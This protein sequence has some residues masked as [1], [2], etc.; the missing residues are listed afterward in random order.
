MI[1]RTDLPAA[2]QNKIATAGDCWE[3]TGALNNRGYGAV[4]D[5]KG[6]SMLAH[7]K[8]YQLTIGA[9]PEGFEI[10][11]LCRM[12]ACINP[13]HLEAVTPDENKRR[14]NVTV[15]ACRS[16]HPLS[17]ANLRIRIR[18][19]KQQRQCITCAREQTRAAYARKQGRSIRSKARPAHDAL[20]ATF[21][22]AA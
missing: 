22:V 4:T 3:W 7:R 21:E 17:G 8:V 13:A 12:H 6:G 5:G 11:H 2:M 18:A 9:I 10:D 1:R 19:G 14:Y 20:I 16:N 15:T